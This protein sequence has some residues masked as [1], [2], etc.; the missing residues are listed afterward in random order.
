MGFGRRPDLRVGRVAR[1]RV[2]GRDRV[3]ATVAGVPVFFESSDADVVPS[4]EAFAG[5]FVLAALERGV[6]LRPE[7]PPSATWCANVARLVELYRRWWGYRG[8][9][10][11]D[12]VAARPDAGPPRPEGGQCF[13]GGIDSFYTLVHSPHRRDV[14][15]ALH[16]FDIAL[17][18]ERRMAAFERSLRTV[19]AVTGR[20]AVVLRTSIRR[21]PILRRLSWDRE[22]GSI[23]AAAGHVLAGTI[24]SLVIPASW[25]RA[26]SLGWGSNWESDP[27]WSSDRLRVIH[28]DA[29]IERWDKVPFLASSSLFFAHLRVC[30]ENRVPEGNCGICEKCVR[31]RVVFARFGLEARGRGAF[32]TSRP[33]PA[34]LD[35][36]VLHRKQLEIVWEPHYLGWSLP[37]DV[38]AAVERLV[39]RSH[40]AL[41][42]G[43]LVRLGRRL[44]KTGRHLGRLVRRRP[45]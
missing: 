20:R 18:D 35:A 33:L 29:A 16:G 17:D 5:P 8:P 44:R 14:L 25:S 27:L 4:V 36:L 31:T 40:R 42:A 23:L 13:S 10:P 7:D 38:Q 45:R 21:H 15:V 6:R 12:G 34:S 30:W 1:A 24:G 2:D 28:D 19:A 32:A 3:T 9:D 39:A 22:H 11:L 41:G 26:W 37:P 43:P